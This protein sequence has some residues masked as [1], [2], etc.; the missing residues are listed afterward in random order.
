MRVILPIASPRSAAHLRRNDLPTWKR[1]VSGI[2]G[3]ALLAAIWLALRERHASVPATKVD[4]QPPVVASAP[5]ANASEPTPRARLVTVEAHL[6]GA[7]RDLCSLVDDP[8]VSG[9]SGVGDGDVARRGALERSPAFK[10][11]EGG[12]LRIDGALRGSSDPYARAVGI[13]LNIPRNAQD[14]GAVTEAE[15]R[16]QLAAM[17]T[18]T[19]DPRI[20]A[21]AFRTCHGSTDDG[22][23]ALSVRRWAELDPGNAVPW[24]FLLD[25][26]A[27]RGD[28]SGQQEAWFHMAAAKRFEDREFAQLQPIVESSDDS[29]GGLMAADGLS[30]MAIGIGAAWPWP[31]APWDQ[32]R[33][34]A[35]VDSNRAQLCEKFADVMFEHSD[36]LVGRAFGA[37]L[38]KRMA[39]DASRSATVGAEMK[40][41]ADEWSQSKEPSC[42]TLKSQL[43]LLLRAVAVGPPAAA[44]ELAAASAAR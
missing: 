18:A 9:A 44:R 31:A 17:A 40:L 41:W 6:R 34:A 5:L 22:C 20:Y 13:W 30:I 33:A 15:R 11:F 16:R 43:S 19:S 2:A 35:H 39:G 4:R 12:V 1:A 23:H 3:L 28:V 27:A 10:A 26:A 29:A 36:S 32:C 8:V 7:G 24:T 25:E 14:D 38:T 21:L 37:A 42:D